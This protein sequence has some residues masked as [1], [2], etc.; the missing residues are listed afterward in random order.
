MNGW[1]DGSLGALL[2]AIAWAIVHWLE[3]K[4]AN[5]NPPTAPTKKSQS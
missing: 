5:P 3:A 1:E 2:V 4:K